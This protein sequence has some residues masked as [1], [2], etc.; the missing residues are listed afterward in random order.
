MVGRSQATFLR[1]M[2]LSAT[3][4]NSGYPFDLAAIAGIDDIEFGPVTIFVGENGSG[5][6][7]I[8]E[9]L[10]TMAGL[11]AEGGSKNLQFTTYATHSNLGEHLALRWARRPSWGWFLRAETFYG[12]ATHIATDDDP[13]FGI[14]S[15][16]PD[17]HG[18]SHGES[19]L[20]L[21]ESRF[22]G[23]G[24]YVMDEPESALSFE[25]QLRLLRVIHDGVLDNSQYVIATHSPLLMRMPAA[26]IYELGDDGIRR[27]SYDDLTVVNLW[28]RFLESPE[29]LLE[30]LFAE[31]DD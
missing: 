7:T 30:T 28:R 18:R 13:K 8:V 15:M 19:F 1:S 3:A 25:G 2:G 14:A 27:C 31:N 20:T 29:R 10:A 4:P 12:M 16:F 23:Q 24:F 9:A 6:S 11:N 5:K 22:A 21:I 17:L 26:M